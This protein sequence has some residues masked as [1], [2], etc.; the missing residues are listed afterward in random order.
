[1]AFEHEKIWLKRMIR[2]ISEAINAPF[3]DGIPELD[4]DITVFGAGSASEKNVIYVP[5]TV[6]KP[7]VL[8]NNTTYPIALQA[9]DDDG[10]TIQ[11]DKYVTKGTTV[12]DDQI[13][14][15]SYDKIDVVTKTHKEAI[16]EKKYGKA[17][18][19]LAPVSHTAN[20]PVIVTTG[21]DDGTGRKRMTY[22][23][24]VRAR[25]ACKGWGNDVRLVLCADHLNDILLDR[26]NFGDKLINYN[27]AT[28]ST[29]IAGFNN[30]E[31][32][33]N[34]M[35]L[36]GVKQAFGSAVANA[37][38]GS[39]FFVPGNV[40]K[41][42]G[43]TKQYFRPAAIDPENQTNVLNYRHYFIAAPLQNK[44]IGAIASGVV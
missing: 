36:A 15:A 9:Y 41:K 29:R 38:E 25:L 27:E 32:A 18:H 34:P 13:I 4:F 8:I 22:A 43:L 28:L 35:F 40:A 21:A 30:Y 10:L 20:T 7:D 39:V 37:K 33:N 6:F 44:F 24:Y 42:T 12:S 3:L 5:T 16:L 14:G 17:I 19:A 1:M 23:D 11:L 31:Y 26:A 2:N